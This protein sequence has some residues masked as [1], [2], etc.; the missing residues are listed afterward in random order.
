MTGSP[1]TGAMQGADHLTTAST[2]E[3]ALRDGQTGRGR[4]IESTPKGT[5]MIPKRT[6][7]LT[8]YARAVKAGAP[9][10]VVADARALYTAAR[11]QEQIRAA[12][13]RSPIDPDDA[14][15]LSDLI[16]TGGAQG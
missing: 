13:A 2:A 10:A 4:V 3:N 14:R 8:E 9:A 15:E 1:S 7:A 6:V 16:L 5:P 11:L 12:L